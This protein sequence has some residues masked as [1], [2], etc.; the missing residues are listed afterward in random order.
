MQLSSLFHKKHYTHI[1]AGTAEGIQPDEILAERFPLQP[2]IAEK[3]TAAR[4]WYS[5]YPLN[6]TEASENE[7]F[8]NRITPIPST[9]AFISV[10]AINQI[11]DTALHYRDIIGQAEHSLI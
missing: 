7:E 3:H 8:R 1:A 2:Y 5:K 11:I 4:T 10:R 6:R 9:T